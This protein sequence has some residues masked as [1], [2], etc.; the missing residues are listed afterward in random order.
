[1][2][3]SVLERCNLK[4]AL[5]SACDT[6]E[7]FMWHGHRGVIRE[8]LNDGMEAGGRA[9]QESKPRFCGVL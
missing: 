7:V 2:G 4:R 3:L 8:A 5:V 1:M 6:T 9:T